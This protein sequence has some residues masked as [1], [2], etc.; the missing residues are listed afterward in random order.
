MPDNVKKVRY[1]RAVNQINRYTY[2]QSILRAKEGDKMKKQITGLIGIG[3]QENAT[4]EE[5][6]EVVSKFYGENRKLVKEMRYLEFSDPKTLDR[7]FDFVNRNDAQVSAQKLEEA[8]KTDDIEET[9]KLP[10]KCPKCQSR[11]GLT[12]LPDTGTSVDI[13]EATCTRGHTFEVTVEN[14]TG[15]ISISEVTI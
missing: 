1:S 3:F 7:V 8:E 4:D 13:Y 11:L 12:P 5:I 14:Q 15:K 10:E 2:A 6:K 9:I